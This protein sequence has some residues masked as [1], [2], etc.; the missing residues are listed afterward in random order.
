MFTFAIDESCSFL[1]CLQPK[2]Y[3]RIKKT[4]VLFEFNCV[5]ARLKDGAFSMFRRRK[6]KNKK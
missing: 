6:K 3:L 2:Q 5:K 1:I 4:R